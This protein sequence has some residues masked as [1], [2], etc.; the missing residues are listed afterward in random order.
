MKSN[1]F[2]TLVLWLLSGL[3]TLIIQAIIGP[4]S[5]DMLLLTTMACTP[6]IW[7]GRNNDILQNFMR[8]LSGRGEPSNNIEDEGD[9]GGIWIG[10]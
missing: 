2:L 1:G 3:L 10:N 7:I 4:F 9:F 8:S 5:T 6:A